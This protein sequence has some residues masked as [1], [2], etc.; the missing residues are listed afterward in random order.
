[1]Q[2]WENNTAPAVINLNSLAR[3]VPCRWYGAIE[4]RS[5]EGRILPIVIMGD[6]PAT[7]GL[8]AKKK[9]TAKSQQLTMT[10]EPSTTTG[11]ND[12]SP[13]AREIECSQY[14]IIDWT[15]YL[16]VTDSV[17]MHSRAGALQSIALM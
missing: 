8:I 16:N 5:I 13:E 7:P 9:R 10:L 14:Q 1:M 4:V 11:D 3:V 6:A 2:T 12:K 17:E 15:Y